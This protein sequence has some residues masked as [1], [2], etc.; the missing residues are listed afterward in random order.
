MGKMERSLAALSE[1]LLAVGN[2]QMQEKLERIKHE[3]KDKE[4]RVFSLLDKTAK[5]F[6]PETGN[7]EQGNALRDVVNGIFQ[8]FHDAILLWKEEMR[9]RQE[10]RQK[11]E[12]EADKN[13]G[14]RLI[15]VVFGRTNAGK[16]TLGNFLRGKQ[17]REAAFDNAWKNGTIKPGPIR[18]IE[19]DKSAEEQLSAEW[20]T[21]GATE[22][23]REAQLFD[24]PGFLWLDTPGFGS[25][26]DESLGSLARKYVKRADLVIYLEHSDSPGLEDITEQFITIMKEGRHA[27]IAINQSDRLELC[28]GPDGKTIWIEKNGPDGPKKTP[29]KKLVAKSAE[30]RAKQEAYLTSVME[31]K[32]GGKKV[33]AISI[34]TLLAGTAVKTNDDAMYAASNMGA[35]FSRILDLISDDDSF[36][37]LKS[38]DAVQNCIALINRVIG[39]DASRDASEDR[40]GKPEENQEKQPSLKIWDTRLMVME[41]RVEAAE[42]A[43]NI[44]AETG[45]ITATIMLQARGPLR[46]LVEGAE[47]RRETSREKTGNTPIDFSSFFGRRSDAPQPEDKGPEID[48]NP[49]LEDCA[50]EAGELMKQKAQKLLKE[51]WLKEGLA[52]RKEFARVERVRLQ[53]RTERHEYEA[54][55]TESYERDP[56]GFIEH[57]TSFFGRKHYGTRVRKYMKEQIIDLGYNTE[58]VYA[59]LAARMEQELASFVKTGLEQIRDECL[60]RGLRMLRDRRE[61][62]LK[63]EE[64]L[65]LLRGVLE[66]RL[67]DNPQ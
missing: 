67:N 45:N 15:V 47:K 43:F 50:T 20:L 34:S 60:T 6:A 26:N 31:S 55:T 5:S 18:I 66:A 41:E 42:K 33:E 40:G 62:L 12:A 32:L 65:K 14:A 58:E 8:D 35:L 48:I 9:E 44:D 16:S 59:E 1:R 13:M 24:L 28:K 56:E 23:T 19:K 30:D 7:R 38:R 63:T 3:V 25:T 22:T 46:N 17:L 39:E 54:F 29:L 2:V 37:A 57:V 36:I 49:L 27:L 21:E 4:D 64:Q 61:A 10:V 53:R 11:L 52:I 51:L